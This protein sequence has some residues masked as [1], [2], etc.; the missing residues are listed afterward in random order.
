MPPNLSSYHL[1]TQLTYL[2][3]YSS[4]P[5]RWKTNSIL[6]YEI[7]SCVGRGDGASVERRVAGVRYSWGIGWLVGGGGRASWWSNERTNKTRQTNRQQLLSSSGIREIP[8]G[9]SERSSI[10]TC[11]PWSCDRLSVFPSRPFDVLP[12][13]H[14]C[15]FVLTA[16]PHHGLLATHRQSSANSLNQLRALHDKTTSTDRG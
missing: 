12:K 16:R 6:V 3:I 15:T 9:E 10:L 14:R 8:A 13:T 1:N 11:C 7:L 4:T 2:H 5:T